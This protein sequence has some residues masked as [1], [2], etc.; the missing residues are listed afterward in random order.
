MKNVRKYPRLFEFSCLVMALF[1]STSASAGSWIDRIVKKF[2]DPAPSLGQ[3]YSTDMQ[4]MAPFSC[5]SAGNVTTT[6]GGSAVVYFDNSVSFEKVQR[7]LNIDVKASVGIGP[8]SS[9]ASAEYARFIEQDQYSQSFYYLEKVFLPTEVWNPK[10][11]GPKILNPIGQGAYGDSHQQFR[12][13]C[14]DQIITQ[15]NVGISLYVTMK[16]LFSSYYDK[17]TFQANFNANYGD[18]ASLSVAVQNMVS[19]YN[20]NGE[21]EVSAFQQGGNPVQLPQIFAKGANGYY[22][23]SCSLQDLSA[24]QLTI[25]GVLSY[26]QN[27][28]PNQTSTGIGAP[29]SFIMEP[30]EM[31]AINT[32]TSVVNST[33]TAARK[34]IGEVYQKQEEYYSFVNDLL[35]SPN[36][37]TLPPGTISRLTTEFENLQN[38]TQQF[39]DPQ[40]GG[41][42][43][44][45]DPEQCPAIA[46]T[47]F[48]NL[49]PVN[50][51]YIDQ[52]KRGLYV[53]GGFMDCTYYSNSNHACGGGAGWR[54]IPSQFWYPI[55]ETTYLST[56]LPGVE[57]SVLWGNNSATLSIGSV[58]CP[59]ATKSPDYNH[60]SANVCS[61]TDQ[62]A[63][64]MQALGSPYHGCGNW[65]CTQGCNGNMDVNVV[66]N[67]M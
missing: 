39:K 63:I 46:A 34:K 40:S 43:C 42:A 15:M 18:I 7:E 8:F 57:L 62:T 45:A 9:S 1:I 21:V 49:A 22:V 59:I 2:Q 20:L 11:Y 58:E 31:L 54:Q 26:A 41:Y 29:L 28:L 56:T 60:Y 52:F 3:G 67:P 25:D 44:Y 66:D 5:Y 12:T 33:V 23:T 51:K 47:L 10:D 19:Q 32:G 36:F 27:N 16:I 38:N 65:Q 30:A 61:N 4:M 37:N 17:Q 55:N 53:G 24:C 13:V 48:S 14:G 35:Q 50:Y 6:P 64:C